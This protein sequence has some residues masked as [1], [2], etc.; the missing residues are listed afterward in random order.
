MA[1]QLPYCILNGIQTI[2]YAY[3]KVTLPGG[4]DPSVCDDPLCRSI[5][6]AAYCL[7]DNG[8]VY[9]TSPDGIIYYLDSGS[10]AT[11]RIYPI[12]GIITME[13]APPDL[14]DVIAYPS[15]TDE[16]TL[17]LPPNN[18]EGVN[19]ERYIN[20]SPIRQIEWRPGVAT[21]EAFKIGMDVNDIPTYVIP[22]PNS[23]Y[24]PK[25][26]D[27]ME[28]P[29]GNGYYVVQDGRDKAI[30]FY[31]GEVIYNG[32]Y[33][34][35]G[36]ACLFAY[37]LEFCTSKELCCPIEAHLD[38]ELRTRQKWGE[39]ENNLWNIKSMFVKAVE[40][41]NVDNDG[42]VHRGNVLD[43]GIDGEGNFTGLV[44]LP[45]IVDDSQQEK[46][47][48]SNNNE[49]GNFLCPVFSV[50]T[51]SYIGTVEVNI[52]TGVIGL[53]AMTPQ[54]EE[55]LA[56]IRARKTATEA[57][58]ET[59]NEDK[60]AGDSYVGT[61][62]HLADVAFETT[63]SRDTP[64]QQAYEEARQLHQI[65]LDEIAD[66]TN[67]LANDYKY[68]PDLFLSL[69]STEEL[70]QLN[71]KRVLWSFHRATVWATPEQDEMTGEV[72]LG[73]D[74]DIEYV[75]TETVTTKS[76]ENGASP[77]K[78]K[79][80]YEGSGYNIGG[81]DSRFM[82]SKWREE[83]C[84]E[85]FS[86]SDNTVCSE[87]KCGGGCNCEE[88]SQC[89][90]DCYPVQ[91]TEEPI[92]SHIDQSTCVISEET[93]ALIRKMAQS[94][95]WCNDSSNVHFEGEGYTV[96]GLTYPIQTVHFYGCDEEQ[97]SGAT[98]S[99]ELS[100][101]CKA[102]VGQ[103][104]VDQLGGRIHLIYGST[105]IYGEKQLTNWS[106]LQSETKQ[107]N[108]TK[109]FT[110]I[111]GIR[112]AFQLPG[113]KE[114]NN[115]DVSTAKIDYEAVKCVVIRAPHSR[116]YDHCV[117]FTEQPPLDTD[118]DEV[119]AR[120][121]QF[122]PAYLTCPGYIKDYSRNAHNEPLYHLRESW[123]SGEDGTNTATQY[124]AP[125]NYRDSDGYEWGFCGYEIEYRDGRTSSG[126]EQEGEENKSGVK[127]IYGVWEATEIVSAEEQEAR[128]QYSE[129]HD[130]QQY[131][132]D[133]EPII[134]R[135]VPFPRPFGYVELLW[136]G[137]DNRWDGTWYYLGWGES[138]E[139]FMNNRSNIPHSNR[140]AKKISPSEVSSRIATVRARIAEIRNQLATNPPD[141]IKEPLER[142]L[143]ELQNELNGL[144]A[145]SPLGG[146][147]YGSDTL[148]WGDPNGVPI[149]VGTQ[150]GDVYF[151]DSAHHNHSI[152]DLSQLDTYWIW[153]GSKWK[154]GSVPYSDIT[155]E[156][157]IFYKSSG[158]L[159]IGSDEVGFDCVKPKAIFRGK[160]APGGIV[161]C[162]DFLAVNLNADHTY[163][164]VLFG[165]ERNKDTGV[166]SCNVIW[167]QLATLADYKTY[168]GKQMQEGMVCAGDTYVLAVCN[169]DTNTQKFFL[170]MAD[171]ES[172]EN[173]DAHEHPATFARYERT[174]KYEDAPNI[175]Y[176]RPSN[177]NKTLIR[178]YKN[179]ILQRYL[180]VK[181]NN[182]KSGYLFYNGKLIHTYHVTES[183]KDITIFVPFGDETQSTEM[184]GAIVGPRYAIIKELVD[185]GSG[186]PRWRYSVYVDGELVIENKYDCEVIFDG[187]ALSML[188]GLAHNNAPDYQDV[189][190]EAEARDVLFCDAKLE[191]VSWYKVTWVQ[192]WINGGT[193][194]AS[195]T[196][197]YIDVGQVG[198]W[199]YALV[200]DVDGTRIKD[201]SDFQLSSDM[202]V[203]ASWKLV[204]WNPYIQVFD[205]VADEQAN[206]DYDVKIPVILTGRAPIDKKK[207]PT[208]AVRTVSTRV[209]K[210]GGG[211]T[212]Y[213]RDVYFTNGVWYQRNPGNNG[214]FEKFG[215]QILTAPEVI[216]YDSVNYRGTVVG[217]YYDYEYNRSSQGLYSVEW[218]TGSMFAITLVSMGLELKDQYARVSGWQSE[219]PEAI[220]SDSYWQ[221]MSSDNDTV[222]K[223]T[224]CKQYDYQDSESHRSAL[225]YYHS[226][227]ISESQTAI[228]R[229]DDGSAYIL[230]IEKPFMWLSKSTIG[231][232]CNGIVS[233]GLFV[234]HIK[235][236]SENTKKWYVYH[237]NDLLSSETRIVRG[238]TE[239]QPWVWCCQ[240]ENLSWVLF[241]NGHLYATEKYVSTRDYTG[242]E[243][244]GC[245]GRGLLLMTSDKTVEFVLL[246]DNN[247]YEVITI[248][249][250]RKSFQPRFSISCCGIDYYLIQAGS[251]RKRM[252]HG[253]N[254][255]ETVETSPNGSIRKVIQTLDI[256]DEEYRTLENGEV[257][258]LLDKVVYTG[259]SKPDPTSNVV[260]EYSYERPSKWRLTTKDEYGFDVTT[261]IDHDYAYS[262]E[263]DNEG[264]VLSSEMRET[265][266]G[267]IP[268]KVTYLHDREAYVY[269]KETR[270][271]NDPRI[272]SITCF[273]YVNKAISTPESPAEPEYHAEA[274][275]SV[276]YDDPYHQ[277]VDTDQREW[278]TGGD[279]LTPSEQHTEIKTTYTAVQNP[280]AMGRYSEKAVTLDV[281]WDNPCDCE[282]MALYKNTFA[283][284]CLKVWEKDECTS[285]LDHSMDKPFVP[286]VETFH[287][288]ES[289]EDVVAWRD[290]VIFINDLNT[291]VRWDRFT[292]ADPPDAWIRNYSP[293]VWSEG[294]WLA[295]PSFNFEQ[296]E[297]N[298][299]FDKSG[300]L[301]S[302]GNNTIFVWDKEY[303]RIAFDAITGQRIQYGVS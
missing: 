283:N 55:L 205:Y 167:E 230:D 303:G 40:D 227:K 124:P 98:L 8:D 246:K 61:L 45:Y 123:I 30:V 187:A 96:A 42:V 60:I 77:I 49:T 1:N 228:A 110:V 47:Y 183:V 229:K 119:K 277:I 97:D 294:F 73:C 241:D 236:E 150:I 275:F 33:N 297:N 287:G 5:T 292:N 39:S 89:G 19:Y 278:S 138:K 237:G 207:K 266:N 54:E 175:F 29:F 215:M 166:E 267:S 254:Y 142:E 210:D 13:N 199:K 245:C 214:H 252:Y 194:E 191:S 137:S 32:P 114:I 66:L 263:T 257:L 185:S 115:E 156:I 195:C 291:P 106:Y 95:G 247:E 23:P 273:R 111:G 12:N 105:G 251:F 22:E 109:L 302:A 56:E 168:D 193:S 38:W 20:P 186:E 71:G 264:N 112:G 28:L 108:N 217:F 146:V 75:V 182:M 281:D 152:T 145:L 280:V 265:R 116:D 107:C 10:N 102:E 59:L 134:R 268:W 113:V 48:D 128:R 184:S 17:D 62:E 121:I 234:A 25:T 85:C 188:S 239:T 4:F 136:A 226:C 243:L 93:K 82:I 208:Q 11:T 69:I 139:W 203:S 14:G 129:I 16:I 165:I 172:G 231:C 242:A 81:S 37:A 261:I 200:A 34:G 201:D 74:Y 204:R 173:S 64:E 286:F 52:L 43:R 157:T 158:A 144:V 206:V 84:K 118:P 132:S 31:K 2:R 301:V 197:K 104:K 177:I 219:L 151:Y 160:V 18:E 86:D 94:R 272:T 223:R 288:W 174:F 36:V 101:V 117:G 143:E 9:F 83:C 88:P 274:A 100:H 120:F 279:Y 213:G 211:Y 53:P 293:S 135:R 57:R 153:D 179:D 35:S 300:R 76:C 80:W 295:A 122:Y 202:S 131:E 140:I 21:C 24:Y 256:D 15:G 164:K 141:N 41:M 27:K 90:K 70:T 68:N 271:S 258:E 222:Y 220:E 147:C 58:L 249:P 296:V 126:S 72:V 178:K 248:S 162:G 133:G 198:D 154:K 262:F 87:Y 91:N 46:Q 50:A 269:Y 190:I 299:F 224:A 250:H 67:K 79:T 244:I 233:C 161:A 92:W 284:V 221:S 240:S 171:Y 255:N 176:L 259:R 3:R 180:F 149:R 298:V 290:R 99:Q 189:H 6:R 253:D 170:F 148:T 51:G 7:V 181:S 285:S 270:V 289:S 216:R 218:P 196:M 163:H 282:Q 78:H 130:G 127:N 212:S 209:P 63:G 232:D 192:Q 235:E 65:I 125:S 225:Y 44:I 276:F 26:P 103:A 238:L 169:E 159:D 260:T 155:K